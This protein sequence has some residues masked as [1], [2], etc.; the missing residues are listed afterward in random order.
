MLSLEFFTQKQMR[1]CLILQLLIPFLYSL[2]VS[3]AQAPSKVVNTLSKIGCLRR[4][5]FF[6]CYGTLD[7]SGIE[8]I[9]PSPNCRIRTFS[10]QAIKFAD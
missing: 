6:S 7:W 5:C 3:Y 4:S 8:L 2:I 10:Y 1:G 9:D